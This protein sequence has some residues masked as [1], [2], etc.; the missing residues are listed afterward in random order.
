MRRTLTLCALSSLLF[1]VGCGDDDG[2]S[3][4]HDGGASDAGASDASQL[5]A[6]IEGVRVD[7]VGGRCTSSTDCRGTGATC[8]TSLGEGSLRFDL[9]DGYCTATCTAHA[10][11]GAGGGCP[12][13]EI[14]RDPAFPVDITSIVQVPSVCLDRCKASEASPCRTGYV[15]LSLR[16]LVPANIRNSP[17][18]LLLLGPNFTDTYCIPPVEIMLPGSDA[19]VPDGGPAQRITAVDGMD[20]GL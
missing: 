11:C 12:L 3:A 16:D 14:M 9:P 2:E 5:D 20:A 4:F 6:G 10:E 1:V 15:C 13:G 7:N 19:G 8:L 17:I 18:G